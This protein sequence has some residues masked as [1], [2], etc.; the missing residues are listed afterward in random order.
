MLRSSGPDVAVATDVVWSV[1]VGHSGEPVEMPFCRVA[2]NLE[3]LEKKR[4]ILR[5]F[6]GRGKLGE[7]CTTSSKSCNKVVLIRHLYI[8]VKQLLSG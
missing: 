3:N 7:W 5:D 4:R 6:S 8:C 1:R 2:T